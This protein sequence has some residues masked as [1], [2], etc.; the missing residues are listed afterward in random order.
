MTRF[1][2]TDFGPIAHG[3]VDLKPLTIFMGPNNSGKSYMA[4]ALYAM[5]KGMWA[6]YP[7]KALSRLRRSHLYVLS[8]QEIDDIT[9]TGKNLLK[10]GGLARSAELQI[11]DL[12]SPVFD[13]V[14]LALE[15]NAVID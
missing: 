1:E 6:D 7:T 11:Q 13:I 12:P 5:T 2:V 15:S 14:E 10:G 9:E 8:Q 3:A 4:L